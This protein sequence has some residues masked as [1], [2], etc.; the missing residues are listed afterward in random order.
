MT[1]QAEKEATGLKK[2]LEVVEQKAKDAA[3][4]L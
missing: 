2:K 1:R 4:D 3:G